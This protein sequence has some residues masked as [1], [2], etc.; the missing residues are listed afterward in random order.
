MDLS[1]PT[2]APAPPNSPPPNRMPMTVD[3]AKRALR[4]E[5]KARRAALHAELGAT[6]PLAAC[7][8][9]LNMPELAA[10]MAAGRVA[11]GY[12]PLGSELD[13]R[14]LLNHLHERGLACTLP[15]TV[16]PGAPLAFRRWTPH[17]QLAAAGYGTVAP[18]PEAEILTPELILVP[19]LAVDAKGMRLGHGAGYYD[20][21]LR[22]LRAR[23]RVVAVGLAYDGQLVEAVPADDGD[24]RLDWLVSERRAIH[25]AAPEG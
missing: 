6:A 1:V 15:A 25:F 23:G 5:A 12:W 20:L 22:A 19:L 9:F 7:D 4:H 11:A 24:E 13:P 21:S 10:E 17:T 18:P 16:R 8:V 3:A 2:A 14:P